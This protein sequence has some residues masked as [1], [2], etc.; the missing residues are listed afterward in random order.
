MKDELQRVIEKAKEYVYYCSPRIKILIRKAALNKKTLLVFFGILFFS[1]GFAFINSY[2]LNRPET[3]YQGKAA[4]N[5]IMTYKGQLIKGM[6][7]T[8]NALARRN[9]ILDQLKQNPQEILS[10]GILLSEGELNTLRSQ[11]LSYVEELQKK[12][13]MEEYVDNLSG[14]L[15][16]VHM[17]DFI[18][19]KVTYEYV[20]E[21]PNTYNYIHTDNVTAFE[22]NSSI[23][24]RKG[25][26]IANDI[27]VKSKNIRIVNNNVLGEASEIAINYA[28]IL[29]NFND[30]KTT[31]YTKEDIE[32]VLIDQADPNS[33]VNYY[34]NISNDKIKITFKVY[35]WTTIPENTTDHPCDYGYH[36]KQSR[37]ILKIDSEYSHFIYLFN[38]N[39][40]K[41]SGYAWTHDP[42][43][44]GK[45]HIWFPNFN[46]E[47]KVAYKTFIHEIGHHLGYNHAGKLKCSSSP[48]SFEEYGNY[49]DPMSYATNPP[50][51]SVNGIFQT[52]NKL[53]E[54]VNA[55]TINNTNPINNYTLEPRKIL[56]LKN[57][58]YSDNDLYLEMRTPTNYDTFADFEDKNVLL[59]NA[60]L[61]DG[62]T[63]LISKPLKVGKSYYDTHTNMLISFKE[64]T[65]NQGIVQVLFNQIETTPF[66]NKGYIETRGVSYCNNHT[67][68]CTRTYGCEYFTSCGGCA[69]KG[70]KMSFVCPNYCG[71]FNFNKAGCVA[72][73]NRGFGCAWYA[74]CQMCI[75]DQGDDKTP[76]PS[77]CPVE[78]KGLLP[79]ELSAT[80]DYNT[81]RPETLHFYIDEKQLDGTWL[82]IFDKVVA[83]TPEKE[84][85][86]KTT[87]NESDISTLNKEKKYRAWVAGKRGGMLL[88]G[89]TK[90]GECSGSI[91]GMFCE[92]SPPGFATFNITITLS[93]QVKLTFSKVTM[94]QQEIKDSVKAVHLELYQN[95]G[96]E[97]V[98]IGSQNIYLAKKEG[99]VYIESFPYDY[100]LTQ[101]TTILNN[102]KLY[103]NNKYRLYI[104]ASTNEWGGAHRGMDIDVYVDNTLLSRL[105]VQFGN[106]N[107]TS[108][109]EFNPPKN[110]TLSL[111]VRK[112]EIKNK[113]SSSD[114]PCPEYY[115]ISDTLCY[116]D[117][118]Y[119][120]K[121]LNMNCAYCNKG[122]WEEN[123]VNEKCR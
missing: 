81:V 34:K 50:Y 91:N 17:D 89:Q 67:N 115:C 16:I 4:L 90:I 52:R 80:L 114:N 62:N 92:F 22:K 8:K 46:T 101:D 31:P 29:Y 70:T 86:Y 56:K 1:I 61:K 13:Y 68:D 64:I 82:Q 111:Y 10:N 117:F 109:I 121:T 113:S 6:L 93:P 55:K 25:V 26:K 103:K 47:D 33:V 20:L 84:I 88:L 60:L 45:L 48:C 75:N 106:N 15:N 7:T 72:S 37:E 49:Y 32:K 21:T 5:Q 66:P 118:S 122:I 112:Q 110:L 42:D 97:H 24:I 14:R 51:G 76:L 3:P 98:L 27:V 87:I 78:N 53:V 28:V 19:K 43:I 41:Y 107:T 104:G 58:L 59:I 2:I 96:G 18:N 83:N 30:D 40:C 85:P 63:G 69:L 65:N 36:A 95:N 79:L 120:W 116:P 9:M 99:K 35:D 74:D 44:N 94:Y 12:G 39:S 11:N 57:P 38:K 108:Y 123:K 23:N 119:A 102:K 105:P 71:Q 100:N 54:E 73:Q 77:I